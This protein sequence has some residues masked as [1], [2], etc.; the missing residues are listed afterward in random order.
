MK[1]FHIRQ[2]FWSLGPKFTI[3]DSQGQPCYEVA[4]RF[5]RFFPSYEIKR[6]DGRGVSTIKRKLSFI[7]PRFKVKVEGHDSFFIQKKW[8]WWKARYE[9]ENL[10]LEVRGDLWNMDFDLMKDGEVLAN[11]DQEWFKLTSTYV[12]EVYEEA[13]EKAYE[14]LT[15]VL[16]IAIDHAKA[17]HH[18]Y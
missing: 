8:S 17:E 15:I 13:Y 11:I 7:F 2:K 16:V 10:G 3:K 12:V 6:E 1:V 18:G 4:G 14:D 9:L 5:F